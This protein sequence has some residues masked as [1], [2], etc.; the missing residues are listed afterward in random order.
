MAAIFYMET[1]SAVRL[2]TSPTSREPQFGCV[3][4]TC[5]LS[6]SVCRYGSALRHA[7]ADVTPPRCSTSWRV[8]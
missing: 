4:L 8:Q 1:L 6:L 7:G 3:L 2:Y 5:A